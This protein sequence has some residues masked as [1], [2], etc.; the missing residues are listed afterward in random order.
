MDLTSAPGDHLRGEALSDADLRNRQSDKER[1]PT[2]MPALNQGKALTR[3]GHSNQ[4]TRSPV[5]ETA[6][7][8]GGCRKDIGDLDCDG[9]D[10]GE[11]L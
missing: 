7:W 10:P 9:G 4:V 8:S 2:G 5:E 6:T 1:R 11:L 3:L